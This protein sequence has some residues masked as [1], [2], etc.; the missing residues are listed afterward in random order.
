ML[1]RMAITL[2]QLRSFV[3]VVET[4]SVTAAAD[5]LH[6]TQPSVSAAVSALS[7]ELGVEL[8]QR[9]GR[10]VELKDA[11]K[12]F[13]PYASH[14]IGLLDQGGR[15]S[16]EA[17]AAVDRE[18]RIAA[19]TTA[20]EHIVPPLVKEFSALRPELSLTV[21]VGNRE[22]VFQTLAS[23]KADVAI[24]GRPPADG[25]LIGKPFMKSPILLIT[26]PDDPL[27]R[28]RTVPVS[29]LGQRPWL[30]REPGSGTR[31]MTEEFLARHELRP[32]RLTMGSNGAIKQAARAGM[33]V[34]LQHQ[35]TTALELEHGMLGV[36]PLAEP[37]PVRDW[38]ALWPSTGPLLGPAEDFLDFAMSKRAK[39][40]IE[41]FWVSGEIAP[42]R[43]AGGSR[44]K[45]R[46]Q[47]PK[48][49]R[50]KAR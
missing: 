9:V 18:L 36:I 39:E 42:P 33:G 50:P 2:T 10:N 19:V 45:A 25:Q 7:K 23:H 22:R 3:A 24:G 21:D 15:A 47:K 31:M 37:L 27:A 13:A 8:T 46:A 12:A 11:G 30:L 38:F 34:A 48:T 43:A 44:R 5:E 20:A 16:R 6:V 17:A 35:A 41:Q 1:R 49:R 26:A 28:R 29:E 32:P 4:G 40:H 14:V